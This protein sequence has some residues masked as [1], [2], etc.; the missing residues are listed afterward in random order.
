MTVKTTIPSIKKVTT[1]MPKR[2]RPYKQDGKA[3]REEWKFRDLNKVHWTESLTGREGWEN[4]WA[5]SERQVQDLRKAIQEQKEIFAQEIKDLKHHAYTK[6]DTQWR[7]LCKAY[8]IDLSCQRREFWKLKTQMTEVEGESEIKFRKTE[9]TLRNI[10]LHK[11]GNIRV[12]D[13]SEDKGRREQ[14]AYSEK[15]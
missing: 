5:D 2:Q 12:M 14:K 4:E 7:Q 8:Y 3:E 6:R 1:Y 15:L 13:I 10:R 11:R 9:E